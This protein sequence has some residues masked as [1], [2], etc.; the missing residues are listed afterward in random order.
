M[1]Y[2]GHINNQQAPHA[3]QNY[4]AQQAQQAQQNYQDPQS[5]SDRF[6]NISLSNQIIQSEPLTNLT[7]LN[8]RP[9]FNYM[10]TPPPTTR[11]LPPDIRQARSQARI[12]H[13]QRNN[14]IYPVIPFNIVNNIV[15]NNN[16]NDDIIVDIND[17]II[18][19]PPVL[20]RQNAYRR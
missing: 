14:F 16:N 19:Q 12:M 17:D 8:L 2:I 7:H 1:T 9:E 3:Q 10:L 20:V 6:N 4:Q 15:N 11:R 5:L 13:N 18:Q